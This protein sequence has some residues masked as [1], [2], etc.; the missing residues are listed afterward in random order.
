MVRLA[1]AVLFA[2]ALLQSAPTPVSRSVDVTT[3]IV[4]LVNDAIADSVAIGAY[5]AQRRGIPATQ[6]CHVTTTTAETCTWTQLRNEILTP[7]TTFLSTRPSVLYIV[8]VYGIP[9][10]TS[11]E[12]PSDDIGGDFLTNRDYCAVDREI[13]LIKIAHGI[14]GWR[15][16][17]V[18]N[19]NRHI[20]LSD[21]IYMVCRLDGPDAASV[22]ALV[23]HA[24][25]G[26]A[27]G[28][29]GNSLLDTR[30][31]NNPGDGYTEIDIEMKQIAPTWA[32]FSIPYTHDDLAPVVD[33]ATRP[34]QTH[35]WGWYTGSVVCSDPAWRF[36]AGAV[37]AHLHSF[38]ATTVRSTT[39]RWVGPLV[40]HGITGTCGTVYEPYS[41]GFP[42]GTIFMD[43]FLRGYTFG[44]SMQ[45]ANAYTSWMAVFVGD[46]LYA[47]YA[48]NVV[49]ARTAP[50][51]G[52][53][54]GGGGG[55]GAGPGHSGLAPLV[56]A[57][58]A[59]M[60][61]RRHIA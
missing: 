43:R 52:G 29:P 21:N 53:G 45:M 2:P 28:V 41:V 35:Y 3:D 58:L 38:S 25:Q 6:I 49:A 19:A 9:L 48:S 16:S 32:L 20:A 42:Y 57:L 51:S 13:E 31:L 24:L 12:D 40:H 54:G 26:E 37:G 27:Q 15:A 33:L 61:R 46:P 56:I 30:G 7:L 1:L 8:P 55:C 22:S 34:D 44:E 47:P 36:R 10:R 17:A 5:Y 59:L 18:F 23:D 39:S 14:E 60:L 50:V 4:I 11:E